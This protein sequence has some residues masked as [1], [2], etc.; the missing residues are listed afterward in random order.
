M[1]D[2][3]LVDTIDAADLSK[4]MLQSNSDFSILLYS[5]LAWA[6]TDIGE[7]DNW[8]AKLADKDPFG[9]YDD[10]AYSDLASN[11]FDDYETIHDSLISFEQY[12]GRDDFDFKNMTDED[13]EAFAADLPEEQANNFGL[14]IALSVYD[15]N[16]KSLV[17]FFKNDPNEVALED[18]YPILDAM[19]EGQRHIVDF[20]GL[21]TLVFYAQNDA[22][23]A[24]TYIDSCIS[25]FMAYEVYDAISIYT[26]VDRSIFTDGGVALTNASMRESAS[27]GDSSWYSKEN[28]DAALAG[29]L[30]TIAGGAV[31]AAVAVP[32]YAS[33][34]W[35]VKVAGAV[36]K[37]EETRLFGMLSDLYKTDLQKKTMFKEAIEELQWNYGVTSESELWALSK[38][39]K[40]ELAEHLKEIQERRWLHDDYMDAQ[41]A[42]NKKLI[43]D[44]Y[45]EVFESIMKK[46]KQIAMVALGISLVAEAIVIGV[47]LYNYYH[48]DYTVIPRM[49]IDNV[50]TETEDYYV[51][52]YAVL[53]QDGEYADLNAWHGTRW[54][55]LYTTK[56]KEAGAPILVS[57]LTAVVGSN[58]IPTAQCYG[59]HYFGELGACNLSR[60]ALKSRA[61][62]I[63]LFFTR[64]HSLRATGSAFSKGTVITFASIG[65]VGGIALGSLG[66]VGATKFKKKKESGTVN[67]E[68]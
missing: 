57:G 35:A 60:Y 9:D 25:D 51:R 48:P 19:S 32:M 2:Y 42:K 13:L 18:L 4:V 7:N 43:N 26:G 6:C 55:A 59:V 58:T 3:L 10:A 45:D 37:Q 46:S 24:K 61:P 22:E 66:V 21:N 38:T 54:N 31:I 39:T 27:T 5:M 63:Y 34:S 14:Y 40:P 56:D 20:V 68:G 53:D 17:E 16:R 8:M 52:Y 47:K 36:V 41:I 23:S 44:K 28:I 62:E 11:V 67:S 12:F 30:H 33:K 65:L 29:I 50:V 49:I 1:G 64:D 15:Y